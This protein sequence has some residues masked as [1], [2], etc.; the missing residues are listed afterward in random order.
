MW[1]FSG[2]EHGRMTKRMGVMWMQLQGYTLL[3]AMFRMG[4]VLYKE[5]KKHLD[6]Y[7]SSDVD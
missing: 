1:Q 3:Y 5:E 2:C 6:F 7:L 4:G